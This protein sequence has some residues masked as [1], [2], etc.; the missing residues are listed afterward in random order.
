MGGPN[1]QKLHVE[2][3]GLLPASHLVEI[4]TPGEFRVNGAS[5]DCALLVL[6]T[7]FAVHSRENRPTDRAAVVERVRPSLV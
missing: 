1:R 4:E 6:P 5:D 7:I 3:S 2:S